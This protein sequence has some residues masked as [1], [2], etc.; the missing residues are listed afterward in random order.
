MFLIVVNLS[1]CKF[2]NVSIIK[3]I[4]DVYL[5][6]LYN[7]CIFLFAFSMLHEHLYAINNSIG[8]FVIL[9]K[10]FKCIL[11]FCFWKE[12]NLIYIDKFFLEI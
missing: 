6:E 5:Y 8:L 7:I 11:F 1:L 3:G 4:K 10:C 9:K 2:I 12:S